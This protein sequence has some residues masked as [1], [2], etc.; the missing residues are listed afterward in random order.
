MVFSRQAMPVLPTRDASRRTG[1]RAP[2][3]LLRHTG[4]DPPLLTIIHHARLVWATSHQMSRG[5]RTKFSWWISGVVP[6]PTNAIAGHADAPALRRRE[7]DA[8]AA[9]RRSL[10]TARRCRP[11]RSQLSSR[12]SPWRR[13]TKDRL[14]ARRGGSAVR[15]TRRWGCG[16]LAV[17]AAGVDVGSPLPGAGR[18]ESQRRFFLHRCVI[19]CWAIRL[20]ARS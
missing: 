10:S 12:R 15:L 13:A 8:A 11:G 5:S 17:A 3:P 1:A 18:I 6:Q 19:R 20:I 14:R 9:Q 7:S 16:R 4:M 2:D